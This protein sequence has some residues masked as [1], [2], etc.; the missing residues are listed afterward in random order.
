MIIFGWPINK[1]TL[2]IKYQSLYKFRDNLKKEE[3]CL[4]FRMFLMV[5]TFLRKLALE[6]LESSQTDEELDDG[7]W[8]GTRECWH[9]VRYTIQLA[10]SSSDDR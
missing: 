2:S 7:Y 10:S 8:S 1:G 9:T 4:P 3:Y 6:I 5:P